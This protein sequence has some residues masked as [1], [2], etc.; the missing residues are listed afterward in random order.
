MTIIVSRLLV[1]TLATPCDF[2]K[3]YRL[4][5]EAAVGSSIVNEDVATVHLSGNERTLLGQITSKFIPA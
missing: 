4:L 2:L 1:T 5:S 3:S